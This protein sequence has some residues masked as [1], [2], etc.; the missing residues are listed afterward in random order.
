MG[1]MHPSPHASSSPGAGDRTLR[2]CGWRVV[3]E[4]AGGLL[5]EDNR[6]CDERAFA[7]V[8]RHCSVIGSSSGDPHPPDV[9]VLPERDST[10]VGDQENGVPGTREER[11]DL[12]EVWVFQARILKAGKR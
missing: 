1:G 10:W 6:F 7:R 4:N 12:K 9:Q 2:S 5:P 11:A 8:G 3:E